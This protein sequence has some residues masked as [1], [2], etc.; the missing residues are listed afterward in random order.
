M[1]D[2]KSTESSNNKKNMENDP[3][4]KRFYGYMFQNILTDFSD[5]KEGSLFES[6]KAGRDML[7]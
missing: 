2:F 7:S 4:F 1:T 6:I 3:K 5:I